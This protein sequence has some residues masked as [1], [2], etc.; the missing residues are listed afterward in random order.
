MKDDL[1][2][3]LLRPWIYCRPD[4]PILGGTP[5]TVIVPKSELERKEER[6][7][8]SSITGTITA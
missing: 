2:R 5:Q 6:V 7:F 4:I 8:V 1:P 3:R